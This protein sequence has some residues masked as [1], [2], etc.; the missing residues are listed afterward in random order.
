MLAIRSRVSKLETGKTEKNWKNWEKLEKPR[1]F[2]Y[3]LSPVD[4]A[5]EGWLNTRDPHTKDGMRQI[6]ITLVTAHI[7]RRSQGQS[8]SPVA[9][10]YTQDELAQ[11]VKDT[12]S[13]YKVRHFPAQFPPF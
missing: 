3:G 8:K 1:A 4:R 5:Y 2:R 9:G 11:A 12:P 13:L 7:Y 10:L 6:L